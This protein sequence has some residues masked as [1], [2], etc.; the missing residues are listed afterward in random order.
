[1]FKQLLKYYSS[2]CCI[3]YFLRT[4]LDSILLN[5]SYYKAA[6]S[7][8]FSQ[9]LK[10]ISKVSEN[11]SYIFWSADTIGRIIEICANGQQTNRSKPLSKISSLNLKVKIEH[12]R[13]KKGKLN[14][15]LL[16]MSDARYLH[17][18]FYRILWKEI[19]SM[20]I[21][22]VKNQYHHGYPVQKNNVCEKSYWSVTVCQCRV[23]WNIFCLDFN[24]RFLYLAIFFK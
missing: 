15:C 18:S 17:D 1:M 24:R 12:D 21:P 2:F 8:R 20:F 7:K 5:Y 4:T 9:Y 6:V 16:F 10:W 19:L 3:I 13:L 23:V 14:N 11:I 22:K